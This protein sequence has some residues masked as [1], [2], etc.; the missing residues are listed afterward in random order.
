MDSLVP[1]IVGVLVE[2][3]Q[4]DVEKGLAVVAHQAHDVVVAPVVEGPLCH[5]E[6]TQHTF[7]ETKLPRTRLEPHYLASSPLKRPC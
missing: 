4:D 7:L 1:V 3:W 6:P 5:L 2:G